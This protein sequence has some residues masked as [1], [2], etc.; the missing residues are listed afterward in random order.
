MHNVFD[1]V[2]VSPQTLGILLEESRTGSSDWNCSRLGSVTQDTRFSC[3]CDQILE[4]NKNK[5]RPK[6]NL[7]PRV[8]TGMVSNPRWIHATGD[9]LQC[10]RPEFNAGNVKEGARLA[11]FAANDKIGVYRKQSVVRTDLNEAIS[12]V[13]AVGWNGNSATHIPFRLR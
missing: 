4:A 8:Q 10:S 1:L 5:H 6:H 9:R 11:D 3:R 13:G 12:V 2:S 7:S